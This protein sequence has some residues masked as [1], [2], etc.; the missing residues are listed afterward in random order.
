[1]PRI[2]VAVPEDEMVDIYLLTRRISYAFHPLAANQAGESIVTRKLNGPFSIPEASSPPSQVDSRPSTVQSVSALTTED[3]D[4]LRKMLQDLPKLHSQMSSREREFFDARWAAHPLAPAWRP[5]LPQD[6][7]RIAAV[8]LASDVADGHQKILAKMIRD[9]VLKAFDKYHLPSASVGLN[10]YIRQEDALRYLEAQ[11]FDVV[12]SEELVAPSSPVTAPQDGLDGSAP[13][14]RQ[15]LPPTTSAKP[16]S[17]SV[18]ALPSAT[19]TP[20]TRSTRPTPDSSTD[21]VRPPRVTLPVAVKL[22]AIELHKH[23]EFEKA[24]E[25]TGI[26]DRKLLA[27]YVRVWRKS[28]SVRKISASPR[29]ASSIFPS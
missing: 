10:S 27:Q 20:N 8:H 22:A 16:N 26:Q 18:A 19:A 12:F 9:G 25:L 14:V 3:R 7:D 23:G 17:Q 6:Q 15:I 13:T 2:R 24:V 5:K 29:P 1:M 11:N 21:D 4:L 28:K